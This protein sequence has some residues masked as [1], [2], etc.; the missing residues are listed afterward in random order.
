MTLLAILVGVVLGVSVGLVCLA[1]AGLVLMRSMEAT[2]RSESVRSGCR[3]DAGR[4]C[5]RCSRP[6]EPDLDALARVVRQGWI[7]TDMI[8][9]DVR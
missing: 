1:I 9:G 6:A 3:R 8:Q 4:K 5:A 7:D 2:G